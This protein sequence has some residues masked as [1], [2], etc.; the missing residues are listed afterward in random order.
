MKPS[1]KY[2][3]LEKTLVDV[4]CPICKENA[5]FD[6]VGNMTNGGPG[7]I[8]RLYH[9]EGCG[10]TPSLRNIIEYNQNYYS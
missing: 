5:N 8:I 2:K 1:L 7:K 6:F 4:D 3:R 9:C 10:S